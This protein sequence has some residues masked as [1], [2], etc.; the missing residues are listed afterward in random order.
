[1]PDMSELHTNEVYP[2]LWSQW[3]QLMTLQQ[4]QRLPHALLF[5][6]ASG[7]GKTALA[8]ALGHLLLCQ[9]PVVGAHG[10]PEACGVC[11]SCKLLEAGTHPDYY[12]IQP[13]PPEKSK[14]KQ[15]VL[16]IRI[17]V[18]RQLCSR[19]SQTS[20]MNG[21]RI[22]VLEQADTMNHAAANSLL[23]TLEEP[24][25]NTL[26]I[27]LTAFPNRLPVTIRS[28]CQQ[29]NFPV[30]AFSTVRDWLLEKGQFDNEEMCQQAFK[31]SHDAP[32]AALNIAAQSE[33]RELLAKALL[34]RF[35]NETVLDYSLKLS[36]CN[37]QQLLSWM[38]DWVSDLIYLKN[39]SQLRVSD[40]DNQSESMTIEQRVVNRSYYR[41]LSSIAQKA[42]PQRIF[43]LHSQILQTPQQGS[44]ALNAQ[45][46]W[47]NLLLS[48]DNL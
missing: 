21:Y 18:I 27:L 14:S 4:Q 43:D 17:D 16:N 26:L 12:S 11:S 39:A 46:L 44:I 40:K 20:Q 19:L 10:Y 28:R 9:Q 30:P 37:K 36:Q 33:H 3:Q 23:K 29:L 45:L 35:N 6:G 42:N 5:A 41:Q 7:L 38:L 47:E 13:R 8:H 2:W 24:G 31:L 32:L 25:Q 34:A 1:M 22:A 15:P 48:W